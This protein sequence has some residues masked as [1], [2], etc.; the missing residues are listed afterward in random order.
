MDDNIEERL[1]DEG[2]SMNRG[3]DSE[4]GYRILHRLGVPPSMEANGMGVGEYD[5]TFY[6]EMMNN[7]KVVNEEVDEDDEVDEEDEDEKRKKYELNNGD[8]TMLGYISNE[9][10]YPIQKDKKELDIEKKRTNDG[11]MEM[12]VGELF[13]NTSMVLNNFDDEFLRALHK[14]DM[15]F[16]YSSSGNGLIKNLKRYTMAFMIYLQ[17][18]NNLLYIGIM[19]FIIS[20]ILYFINIIRKND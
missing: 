17:E 6:S 20:I 13:E 3:F 18:E 2:Y 19:L 1:N 11:I 4:E 16:G 9:I 15:E 8:E 5:S 14:V 12:Q 7:A 10:Y